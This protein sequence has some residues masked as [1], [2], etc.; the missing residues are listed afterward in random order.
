MA[1]RIAAS[2]LLT[3]WATLVVGGLVAYWVTRT[4]LISDL[5]DLL[6][7]RAESLARATARGEPEESATTPR[8][9]STVQDR[10]QVRDETRVI[11]ASG[12][13]LGE[14]PVTRPRKAAFVEL[15]EGQWFRTVT[16]K[17]PVPADGSAH[18]RQ[19]T[20]VYSG[21]ADQVYRVL[22]RLAL[23]LTVCGVA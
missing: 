2:I 13:S 6:T 10:F 12:E 22:S 15:A 18:P 5:D 11:Y 16:V 23:T 19:F 14:R 20:V 21:P 1:R 7:Q 9:L 8:P 3:V 4:V 17:V